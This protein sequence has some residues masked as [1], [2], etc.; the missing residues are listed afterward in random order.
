MPPS[1]LQEYEKYLADIELVDVNTL[2]EGEICAICKTA[3]E[4]SCTALSEA[5]DRDALSLLRE[6]PFFSTCMLSFDH[7]VR[8]PCTHGHLLGLDCLKSWFGTHKTSTECVLCREP[9]FRRSPQLNTFFSAER[10]QYWEREKLLK[11]LPLRRLLIDQKTWTEDQ[12]V[13]MEYPAGHA[14]IRFMVEIAM[15]LARPRIPEV[16]YRQVHLFVTH[17]DPLDS[18]YLSDEPI[19]TQLQ[20]RNGTSIFKQELGQLAKVVDLENGQF[21]AWFNLLLTPEAEIMYNVLMRTAYNLHML[22]LRPGDLAET[23]MWNVR[24]VWSEESRLQRPLVLLLGLTVYAWVAQARMLTELKKKLG[25]TDRNAEEQDEGSLYE[26]E[27]EDEDEEMEDEDAR[28]S[29]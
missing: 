12:A 21:P 23:L 10:I 8:L 20:H 22:E 18:M 19:P 13:R 15:R 24:T 9:I 26:G 29:L 7:P 1:Q 2:D 3:F 25:I 16:P 27:D 4:D 5:L 6:L 14:L 28:E 17:A 11:M